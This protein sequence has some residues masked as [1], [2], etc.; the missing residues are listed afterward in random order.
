MY[1][2]EPPKWPQLTG[3]LIQA[4]PDQAHQCSL[5]GKHELYSYE[6]E[7]RGT[8]SQTPLQRECF[9][10]TCNATQKSKAGRRVSFVPVGDT[11]SRRRW[12]RNSHGYWLMKF[13][14]SWLHSDDGTESC[15]VSKD[16]FDNLLWNWLSL[17]TQGTYLSQR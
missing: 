2:W 1:Q 7:G 13:S 3:E 11:F 15:F 12:H 16:F 14:S 5:T 4:L 6:G 8:E 9:S 17:P 10:L